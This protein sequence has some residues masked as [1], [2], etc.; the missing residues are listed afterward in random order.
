MLE[1]DAGLYDLNETELMWMARLQ[2][3]PLLRYGLP[4]EELVAIVA[5]AMNVEEHHLAGTNFTRKCLEGFIAKNFEL[6]RSQL[7]GCDGKCRSFLC[8]E[9]KHMSC[10][11]PNELVVLGTRGV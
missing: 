11:T 6:I 2:S 10:F 5:G 1:S 8:T 7:P 3:L 9:G 4:H